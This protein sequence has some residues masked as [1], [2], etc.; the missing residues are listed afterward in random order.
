MSPLLAVSA[1]DA[2]ALLIAG[3]QDT[4]VPI[5]HSE[6]IHAAFEEVGVETGLVASNPGR[7]PRRS[8]RRHGPRRRR[9]RRLVHQAPRISLIAVVTSVAAISPWTKSFLSV[10][11][12]RSGSPHRIAEHSDDRH[13]SSDV[14][15][16][17]PGETSFVQRRFVGESRSGIAVSKFSSAASIIEKAKFSS[18]CYPFPIGVLDRRRVWSGQV[19][20]ASCLTDAADEVMTLELMAIIQSGQRAGTCSLETGAASRGR[21]CGP[22]NGFFGELCG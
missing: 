17:C 16:N 14:A 21:D 3:D 22:E 9:N 15:S 20:D 6:K 8:G 10:A 1:G 12:D 4:L 2:P 7:R 19:C 11:Q 18:V 5:W 13:H